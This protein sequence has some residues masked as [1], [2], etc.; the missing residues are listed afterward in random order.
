MRTQA[1]SYGLGLVLLAAIPAVG[2]AQKKTVELGIDAAFAYDLK[3]PKTAQISVPS[4]LFR[5]G[6]FASD[7]ISVEPSVAFNWSKASGD[8]ATTVI[9]ARVGV[10]YHFKTDAAKSRV[11]VEPL[12]GVTHVSSGGESESQFQVGG[13]IGVKLPAPNHIGLRLEALFAHGFEH[14]A[15]SATD[16]IAVLIGFSFFTH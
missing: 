6:F 13:G 1:S 5:V 12:L 4:G 2:A 16:V 8:D 14:G 15:F 7:R 10:L 3:E 9:Q 11:F